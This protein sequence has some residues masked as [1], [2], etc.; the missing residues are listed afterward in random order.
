MTPEERD[1]RAEEW[2][3]AQRGLDW[4]IGSGSAA[5]WLAAY[6]AVDEA[7]TGREVRS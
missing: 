4:Y 2:L 1:R 3:K 5:E 7:Q 6:R